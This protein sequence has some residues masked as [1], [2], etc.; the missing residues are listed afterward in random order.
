VYQTAGPRGASEFFDRLPRGHQWIIKSADQTV[1]GDPPLANL[2]G[3]LSV[4][5]KPGVAGPL[6]V[7]ELTGSR[8][9]VAFGPVPTP[10]T[11]PPRVR[12]PWSTVS[13]S[14]RPLG[15]VYT[16]ERRR[17]RRRRSSRTF[18]GFPPRLRSGISWTCSSL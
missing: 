18:S 6:A 3:P 10:P 2:A 17:K 13:Q 11:R 14:R 7:E 5:P 9:A 16:I 12:S 8:V 15:S 1:A 4:E